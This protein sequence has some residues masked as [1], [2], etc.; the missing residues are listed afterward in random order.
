MLVQA[1]D[2]QSL[3]EQVINP[4]APFARHLAL[5]PGAGRPGSEKLVA[6]IKLCS[7]FFHP[8]TRVEGVK[9]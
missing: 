6:A 8:L 5:V 9:E 1:I 4:L 2:G 3:Y 7:A